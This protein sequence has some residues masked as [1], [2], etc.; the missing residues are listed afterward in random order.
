MDLVI[1]GFSLVTSAPSAQAAGGADTASAM[2][3]A[4]FAQ[5]LDQLDGSPPEGEMESAARSSLLAAEEGADVAARSSPLAAREEPEPAARFSV[6]AARPE[7]EIAVGEAEVSVGDTTGG[8][9]VSIGA[10]RPKPVGSDESAISP[11]DEE[12]EDEDAVDEEF[13]APVALQS[14]PVA[15]QPVAPLP[16]RRHV[17]ANPIDEGVESVGGVRPELE[18]KAFSAVDVRRDRDTGRVTA[19][20]P[21]AL[22]TERRELPQSGVDVEPGVSPVESASEESAPAVRP[23]GPPPAHAARALARALA[24]LTSGDAARPAESVDGN[25]SVA[26]PASWQQASEHAMADQPAPVQ[27]DSALRLTPKG[28]EL[29]AALHR[30]SATADGEVSSE[31][32]PRPT[33]SK[34]ELRRSQTLEPGPGVAVEAS[35]VSHASAVDV[36]QMPAP[37]SVATAPQRSQAVESAPVLAVR[38]ATPPNPEEA[39]IVPQIVRAMRTH[40]RAGV[41]E[42]RIRLNPEHLGEVRLSIRIDGDRVSA[43]LHVE[44]PE[45]QKAIESQSDSLRTG[46]AAQGFTLEHLSV[47]RDEPARQSANNEP[48]QRGRERGQPPPQRRARKREHDQEFELAEG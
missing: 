7:S 25:A 14:L 22:Q 18:P 47:N 40:F 15:P 31:P 46:L 3:D 21:G 23:D 5:L 13:V 19:E 26:Q 28:A 45:V 44:R 6:L 42:A 17:I 37:A 24:R 32:T 16:E 34:V 27:T 48:E 38:Q 4:L 9:Q 11:G 43:L 12:Q 1:A 10:C 30:V 20:V 39:E 29:A 35:V 41:G 36:S 2:P 8:E 33:S